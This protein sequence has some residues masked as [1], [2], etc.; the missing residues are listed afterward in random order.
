MAARIKKGDPV[1]VVVGREATEAEGHRARGRV[2]KVI[3]SRGK[4]IVEG[5]NRVTRHVRPSR[6]NPQGGRVQKEAPIDASNAMPVCP[7]CDRG[8]RVRFQR[9]E[10]DRKVRVCAKCESVLS[11]VAEGAKQ[12]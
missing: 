12:E 6:R 2:I 5:I 1:E 8:V 9:D 7:K 3:P 11:A 4:I 10:Q